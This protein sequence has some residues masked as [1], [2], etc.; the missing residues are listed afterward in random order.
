MLHTFSR[1]SIWR[2]VATLAVV[3]TSPMIMAAGFAPNTKHV[4][5]PQS[6]T[7]DWP[8]YLHDNQR[9]SASNETIFSPSNAAQL[10]KVWSYQTG[11]GVAA[12]SVIVG[13]VVYV[14]S[15]DGNMYALNAGTGALIWKTFLGQTVA[16]LCDPVT[17]GITS[18]AT[19]Q[20]GIV[21][22]GGGDA[23]WYALDASTGN[24]LWR[25]FTG[26]NSPTGGHV[27]W[28]SPLIYNGYAYIGVASNCDNPLAQGQLL[29]VDLT[30]HNIVN[31]LNVV[32]T[33][34]VGGGIWTAPAVDQATNTLYVTTGNENQTTQVYAQAILAI[35]ATTLAV[36]SYWDLSVADAGVDSDWGATPVLFDD[37]QGRHWATAS[38]KNGYLYAFDRT[39]LAA[40]PVWRR[41]VG[42]SG[43]CPPCGD[44]SISTNAYA[45]S[46]IYS[47]GGN[48]TI[49]GLG[50]P[51]SVRALDPA[52]GN[53]LWEHGTQGPVVSALTAVNGLLIDE[54]GAT[55]EV[56]NAATGTRLYSYTTGAPIYSAASISNGKIFTGS[57]DGNIYAIGL[58]TPITPSPD[59]NCPVNWT[60]QDVGGPSPSGTETVAGGAWTI[61][62]GGAGLVGGA[63]QF[64]LLSQ[65]VS[66]DTQITAQVTSGTTAQAGLM[67]RQSNDPGSPF[68]AI[69][70][71]PSGSLQ[72]LSRAR[73]GGA[74]TTANQLTNATLPRYLKLVRVGDTMQAATSTDGTNFTLVPGTT[75]SL[76]LPSSIM[77]GLAVTSG[78]NGNV[79]TANFANITSG[80]P[81]TLPT[82]P[83]SPSACP[84]G[85]ACQDIGNPLT[86]GDQSLS[87][88]VWT[89]K[90]AGSDIN[91]YSDQFHEVW[92]TVAGDA[93]LSA[94]IT[95]QSNTNSLAKV[96][97][98]LRQSTDSGA[99]YYAM[100]LTPGNGIAVQY[101]A[102][103][104]LR[105]T[106][107]FIS[108][109]VP[110]YLQIERSGN[111]F[112]A[113][114]STNGTS[115]VYL[116]GSAT[117]LNTS[118]AMQ[119][120]LAITSRTANTLGSATIDSV[121]V[122]NS[123][124]LPPTTCP[125]G[126]SC[127]DIGN[128]SP[129]GSQSLYGTAWTI[130]AGGSDIY[131]TSDQFHYVWQ[132]LAGDGSISAQVTSQSAT[133]PWAK[134]GVMIRQSTDAAAPFY[135]MMVT[136]ANGLIVQYRTAIGAFVGQ[137]SIAA[138]VTLPM[139]LKVA[140]VGNTFSA[141]TSSDGAVWTVVSTANITLTMS[142]V[143]LAGL[144][145]T[146]HNTS[147]LS[148]V[149][150]DKVEQQSTCIS[151]WSCADIGTPGQIGGNAL[152]NN[153]WTVYGGGTDIFG[154]SDNF[155]YLWQA[156]TGDGSLSA[157]VVT[158]TNTDANAK[159]GLMYRQSV[160]PAAPYYAIY[161][162]PGSG[163]VVQYRKTAGANAGQAAMLA[164]TA[165]AYLKLLR[166][167]NTF[168]AYT[169][170]DGT[171]WTLVAGSSITLGV[172]GTFLAGLA[173]TAHQDAA[174]GAATF[175]NV[176]LNIPPPPTCP[177]PW[178]CTDI[179]NPPLAGAQSLNN[180]VWSVQGNGQDIWALSD[181]FHYVWQS[182][183]GDGTFS[184]HIT[185]QSNTD[186][187]AKAGLMFRQTTDPASPFYAVYMTPGNGITVQYRV[188]QAVY[189]GQAAT[190][191]GTVPAYLR[192]VRVVNVFTAYTSPDGVTWTLIPNS[193]KTIGI[194]GAFLVGMAV[195]SHQVAAL[196]SATF[197]TVALAT[198]APIT[199]PAT[200]TCAD[201]GNPTI[202]GSQ[203]LTN[204]IWTVQGGGTD[205]W[206]TADQFHYVWQTS[207]GDNTLSTHITAQTNTSAW[208][209]A[210]LMF[211]LSTDPAAPYYAVYV[212]P[213][214]GYAV[215]YRAVQGGSA[216]NAGSSIAGTLPV[217]LRI[218][219]VSTTFTAY[220]SPDGSSWTLIPNSSKTI[221]ALS[222][223]LLLGLADN[224]HNS[225][226]LG[227][228]TLDSVT[229]ALANAA[230]PNKHPHALPTPLPRHRVRDEV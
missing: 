144:A 73:F 132:N 76:L 111:I 186:A 5:M 200:W 39:N 162:T 52:T 180:G 227:S 133:D 115:W 54:A 145:A 160:D 178:G 97:V 95:A 210:G 175:D 213:G 198:P 222:G 86:V 65:N 142:G 105:T 194:G 181:Q 16:P 37:A 215:Q 134:A 71:T 67:L 78:T 92:Q 156:Q 6:A 41:M 141:Y 157:R 151:G 179:G 53:V 126:W 229:F 120:G 56:L 122:T 172:G 139:Y 124:P 140:R 159:A 3:L 23:Y 113:Y 226:K 109:I 47:A 171:T 60:C 197:D 81:G 89:L 69:M 218:M 30:T 25:V 77:A 98:M 29:Q 75:A 20:N 27:N 32:P 101:R 80:A 165:P 15:W 121:T 205:I 118:G 44:G 106:Q 211:R 59:A 228:V 107:Q 212:T 93:T 100:L 216:S 136:P 50:Y 31:T 219:R 125:T 161:V 169:S 88:G 40:G 214:N 217:F 191:A 63:D 190:L 195:T 57:L 189:T 61:S 116:L 185:A 154:T 90:G 110:A 170:P 163:I 127:A 87:S 192:V 91:G 196:G 207:A 164:G 135:S 28:S 84:A 153:V 224:S 14:G 131:A 147:A 58:V 24:I 13:G 201:I 167:G 79:A 1:A 42:I 176:I 102:S 152:L 117:V 230:R 184:A 36:K 199:C 66:G 103:E 9:T 17:V 2:L 225:G 183:A 220:T 51:G 173:V 123:A 46:T 72:V 182:V 202:A 83:A 221:A 174:L 49:N 18:T 148:T 82:P 64:R 177:A 70:L 99:A 208:A 48:T 158:Q 12:E 188:A 35:D 155:H 43:D 26:D 150:F 119:A 206:G 34:Q 149:G 108:G 94:H 74:L 166:A 68:Y 22:V 112:T 187:N 45:N 209:K 128:S 146:S 33:G 55:V 96:G 204:G 62:A 85:W 129:S 104:G 11:G 223:S 143:A 130:L 193:T 168:T 21:Y 38:N 19:V 138:S 137:I 8:T 114:T 203:A 7:E 10:A 4:V